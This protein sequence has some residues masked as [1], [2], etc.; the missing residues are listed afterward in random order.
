MGAVTFR[1]CMLRGH[2]PYVRT[3]LTRS[4]HFAG[5]KGC[6]SSTLSH[7]FY[8]DLR[9]PLRQHHYTTLTLLNF[10]QFLDHL[11]QQMRTGRSD[12]LRTRGLAAADQDTSAAVLRASQPAPWREQR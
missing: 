7:A 4:L 11:I 1:S 12:A 3:E 8:G 2:R 9:R 6:L 10:K 5:I